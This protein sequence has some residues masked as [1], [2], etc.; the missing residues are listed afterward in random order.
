MGLEN[1]LPGYISDLDKT[2]PL[3]TDPR[4]QGDDHLRYIKNVLKNTFPGAL[5]QGFNTPILADESEL[6]FLQGTTSN[7]QAQL[8]A[9]NSRPLCIVDRGGTNYGSIA[10]NTPTKIPFTDV[11]FDS[12][13]GWDAV[14][15]WYVVPIAGI[16]RITAQSGATAAG[17]VTRTSITVTN[18]TTPTARAYAEDA[19]GVFAP[20]CRSSGCFIANVGD[21]LFSQISFSGG[22]GIGSGNIGTTFMDIEFVRPL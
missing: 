14:N 6:N 13:S 4:S 18:N 22:S 1:N 20:I 10:A 8:D 3:F 5:G 11:I 19:N 17:A 21:K 2:W 7:V 15:F 12:H 9:A 16:Y